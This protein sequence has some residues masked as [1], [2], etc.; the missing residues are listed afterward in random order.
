MIFPVGVRRE[1]WKKFVALFKPLFYLDCDE[2]DLSRLTNL[3][4]RFN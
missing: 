2:K 1:V 3:C 4:M